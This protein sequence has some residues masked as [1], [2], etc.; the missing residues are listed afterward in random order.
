MG[1]APDSGNQ[2]PAS[3]TPERATDKKRPVNT[4]RSISTWRNCLLLGLACAVVGWIYSWVPSGPPLP[5][6]SRTPQGIYPQLAESL[7]DG[8]IAIGIQPD[9]RL[10]ALPDPYDPKANAPYRIDN[11]SYYW[12][13]YYAYMGLAPEAALFVPIRILTG[14]Y[15]TQEAA[16]IIFCLVG[17]IAALATLL[18]LRAPDCASAPRL[19]VFAAAT[20]IVF[21]GGFEEVLPGS[22]AQDVAVAAGYAFAML[23]FWAL[24]HA[25]SRPLRIGWLAWSAL[26]LGA[27]VSSRPNYAIAAIVLAA[28]LLTRLLLGRNFPERGR[29]TIAVLLPLAAIAGIMMT[30]NVARFGHPFEFGQRFMLG[31]WDQRNLGTFDSAS[32]GPN[33]WAYLLSPARY[34]ATFPFLTA[35]S[36]SA[37]GVILRAPW[38]WLAPIAALAA[39]RF[40]KANPLGLVALVS[41]AVGVINL[42]TL[43]ALPSGNPAATVL[44]ANSRYVLD[45]LPE[46]VLGVALGLMAAWDSSRR[47]K[48]LLVLATVASVVTALAGLSLDF[49]RFPAD[50]YRPLATLLDLPA[51]AI[52]GIRGTKFGPA[53]ATVEFP[54]GNAGAQEPLLEIGSA[55][56][57]ELV[58]VH[59]EGSDRL[60]FGIVGTGL[61]GPLGE[62]IVVKRGVPH[63][64]SISL[65]SMYPSPGDPAWRGQTDDQIAELRRIAWISIDGAI[66]FQAPA[67][68]QPNSA[69]NPC[70]GERRLL[71]GYTS[72]KF[73]GRITGIGQ[74]SLETV[75]L[76]RRSPQFGP[77]RLTVRFP[78]N[79]T[80][81]FEP[82]L[83]TGVP[84]AGD[85]IWVHY[86]DSSHIEVGLDHWGSASTRSDP[87]SVDFAAPHVV[88]ID[89]GS[90]LAPDAPALE[91]RRLEVRI[92]GKTV[93]AADCRPYDSS[94]FD[95]VVAR[96]PIGASSCTYAFTG[97]IDR[98]ERTA[99]GWK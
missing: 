40:D 57:A 20:V 23:S 16:T 27:A 68:F 89:L 52:D 31:G 49:Q 9:P 11:L 36:W 7:R 51:Y 74:A 85:V 22:L 96:N 1:C 94:P 3:L 82:L 41:F 56:S 99:M 64:V 77:V 66:V 13:H 32:I 10:V 44:S 25:I 88:S 63:R 35:P 98:V 47:R 37:V 14:R 26:F 50:S 92:D 18:R 76:E 55:E 87:I 86:L 53:E 80:G 93:L 71:A 73:T 48:L 61:P 8:R 6:L 43:L 67:Y 90:L 39:L 46:L 69:S 30:Y 38:L 60:R 5:P 24:S 15:L 28:V 84:Q 75:K 29:V 62:P 58:Y 72:D 45:F 33:A 42:T 59:Y 97:Q 2:S 83:T 81:A 12:G 21:G 78:R 54:A 65:G 4:T 70:W 91:K 95:V 34:H 19:L 17:T 79:A